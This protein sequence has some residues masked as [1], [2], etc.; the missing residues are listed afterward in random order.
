MIQLMQH[1]NG[2]TLHFS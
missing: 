1:S 2:V